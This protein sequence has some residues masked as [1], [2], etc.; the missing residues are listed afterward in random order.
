VIVLL[1]P[2]IIRG[3]ADWDEQTRKARMALEDMDVTRARVIHLD[4]DDKK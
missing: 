3:A 1:K 4:G 2:T